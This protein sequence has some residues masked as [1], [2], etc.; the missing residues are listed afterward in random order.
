MI[1]GKTIVIISPESWSDL[2]VSKH[3]YAKQ[4]AK[5]NNVYFVNPPKSKKEKLNAI[6]FKVNLINSYYHIRGLNRFP[7]FIG[8]LLMKREVNSILRQL[9]GKSVDLV[10]SFD[11][12]RLYYLDLFNAKIK[13]AHLVDYLTDKRLN[14]W[15]LSAD[16]CFGVTNGIVERIKSVQP[17]VFKINHGFIPKDIKFSGSKKDRKVG[18]YFGNLNMVYIDWK[19]LLDIVV[20]FQE[21]DFQFYGTHDLS[22]LRQNEYFNKLEHESNFNINDPVAYESVY[23]VLT[24]SDFAIVAYRHHDFSKRLENSHKIMQ[25][26]GSGIPIFSSYISE[27]GDKGLFPMYRELDSVIPSFKKFIA[28]EDGDFDQEAQ[29]KRVSYALDNTYDKQLER[30]ESLL[31]ELGWEEEN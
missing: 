1:R 29:S 11:P 22:L 2:H 8:R 4:L 25:Y 20:S 30:I 19:S 16:L 3:L 18:V 7:K 13:I 24:S 9:N 27:Y 6:D 5:N 21:V 12:S 23:N 28:N 31:I 15:L 14:E 17:S 10:W 26:L